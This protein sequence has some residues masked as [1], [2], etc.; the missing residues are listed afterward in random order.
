MCNDKRGK[1]KR[2]RTVLVGLMVV[3]LMS[4]GCGSGEHFTLSG[5]IEATE[6]NIVAEVPGKVLE[7]FSSEGMQVKAGEPIVRLDSSMQVLAVAQ[8]DAV[9]ALKSAKLAELKDGSRDELVAQAKAAVDA[10]TA[11]L[12]EA[13][14]GRPEQVKQAEA[15]VSVASASVETA[16]IALDYAQDGL[17]RADVMLKSDS[18]N[19]QGYED[20]RYRRDTAQASL[21][22][23][24]K[25]LESAKAQ[26][27]T[28]RTGAGTEGVKAAQ[29]AVD[30]AVSQLE[31]LKSGSLQ[32]TLA[33]AE[34][35][36]AQSQAARDQAALM[37]E[38]YNLNAPTDGVLEVVAA[39]E[40]ELVNTGAVAATVIDLSQLYLR[41]YIPQRYLSLVTHG[42]ALELK[43]SAFPEETLTGEI[44]WIASEAEFTPRNTETNDSRENTVFQIKVKLKG[45]ISHYRPG[46]TAETVLDIPASLR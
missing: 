4:S 34:A 38:K 12:A 44:V 36:L 3:M 27:Q 2:T 17:D 28:A 46:M 5:T 8:A 33:M 21:K 23:A 14:N 25:Q 9:V 18:I 6:R 41:M 10:A 40:G 16:K 7:L 39:E 11:R 20:A 35:D 1:T 29:A 22:T 32:T 15:A 37:L 24:E 42:Q 43:T 45:D 13:Q 19:E 26:L 31:L 30:Q